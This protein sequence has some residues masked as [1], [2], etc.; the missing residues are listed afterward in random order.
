MPLYKKSSVDPLKRKF[1]FEIDTNV[2][3]F[4]YYWLKTTDIE[5]LEIVKYSKLHSQTADQQVNAFKMQFRLQ[6]NLT[7]EKAT[8]QNFIQALNENH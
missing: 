4:A 5:K 1:P 7:E 3:E 2:L 6:D 8:T